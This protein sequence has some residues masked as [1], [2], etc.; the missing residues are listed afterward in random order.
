MANIADAFCDT[1]PDH[2]E[3]FETNARVYA[4]ELE[5]LEGELAALLAPIAE[6]DRIVIT[7]HD[8]LAYMARDFDMTILA[9]QGISTESEA[10]AAD[11]ARIIDLINDTGAR[12]MFVD[13]VGDSR[14]L[15]QIASET[16]LTVSDTVLYT[17]ALSDGDG[18]AATYVDMMRHN[19]TAIAQALQGS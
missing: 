8:A 1:A 7:S 13:V 10:S 17:D 14:L 3:A 19:V 15:E 6:E 12:A 16:S 5:A 4:A 2:C 11:V 18:P 9:P